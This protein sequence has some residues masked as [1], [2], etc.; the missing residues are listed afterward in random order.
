MELNIIHH[1]NFLKNN[2]PDGCADLI[3]A[4]PPYF[5]TKGEFDFI[6]PTFEDY[7][8]ESRSLTLEGTDK[9]GRPYYYATTAG[10]DRLKKTNSVTFKTLLD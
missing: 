2:L 4:D 8:K 7:L 9:A 5:E 1:K 10:L 6:W 3:I